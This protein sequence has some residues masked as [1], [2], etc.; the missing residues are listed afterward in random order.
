MR[1]FHRPPNIWWQWHCHSPHWSTAC[2]P[3]SRQWFVHQE[4]CHEHL[5]GSLVC[6][7]W[8]HPCHDTWARPYFGRPQSLTVMLL[9]LCTQWS[10]CRF[11]SS[12]QQRDDLPD[13]LKTSR[14]MPETRYLVFFHVNWDFY[15]HSLLF[16]LHFRLSVIK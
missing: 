14:P 15:G 4:W 2:H 8:A 5:L 10:C 16:E 1:T 3:D 12:R 6:R 7:G 9:H 11:Y 13:I